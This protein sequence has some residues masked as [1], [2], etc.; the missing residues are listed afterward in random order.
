MF[1]IKSSIEFR[2]FH[3]FPM[4]FPRAFPIDVSHPH[5]G[6]SRAGP[7]KGWLPIH[8]LPVEAWLCGLAAGLG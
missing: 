4:V 6:G 3:V 5:R 2:Y 7:P 1:S 8:H